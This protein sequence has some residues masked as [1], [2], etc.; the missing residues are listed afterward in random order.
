MEGTVIC[1][2]QAAD[3]ASKLNNNNNHKLEN[4]NTSEANTVLQRS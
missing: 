4:E 3:L 2:V 1:Q